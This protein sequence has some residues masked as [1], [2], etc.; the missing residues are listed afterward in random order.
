MTY[1]RKHTYLTLVIKEC[2]PENVLSTKIANPITGFP[3]GSVLNI[4]FRD[5]P[6]EFC[7]HVACHIQV[8]IQDSL[9]MYAIEEL[10][11]RGKP[12]TLVGDMKRMFTS[13]SNIISLIRF[14]LG[15]ELLP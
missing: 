5:K 14:Y 8:Y 9:D 2:I 6:G 12:K 10:R 1:Y 4:L 13:I 3:R 15:A 7:L 11:L